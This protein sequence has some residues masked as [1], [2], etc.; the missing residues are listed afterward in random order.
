MQIKIGSD[1]FPTFTQ[2]D[3]SLSNLDVTGSASATRVLTDAL[4]ASSI[5]AESGNF[6][7]LLT[8][9][10][11]EAKGA[12]LACIFGVENITPSETTGAVVINGELQASVL[13]STGIIEGQQLHLTG[14]DGNI[15]SVEVTVDGTG[16][17]SLTLTEVSA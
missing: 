16:T 2:K 15:Y 10:C 6:C 11:L 9:S 13:S 1:S 8:V 5:K 12:K 17:P 14:D 7:N 3:K 4:Y